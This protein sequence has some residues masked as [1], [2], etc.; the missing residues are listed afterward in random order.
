MF[1]TAERFIRLNANLAKIRAV[2]AASATKIDQT[3]AV[4]ITSASDCTVMPENMKKALEVASEV[5]PASQTGLSAAPNIF[6]FT[7]PS[8]E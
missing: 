8:R 5:A 7:E 3:N 2:S 4:P 1:K 6:I